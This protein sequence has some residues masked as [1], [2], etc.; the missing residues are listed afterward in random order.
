MPELRPFQ[1]LDLAFHIANPK[2]LNLSDPGTGK[3]PTACVLFYYWWARKGWRTVWAMPKS[4]MQKNHDELLRFTDFAPEDVVVMESDFAPM[5]QGWTGPTFTREKKVKVKLWTDTATGKPVDDSQLDGVMQVEPLNGPD[6]KQQTRLIKVPEIA[7]DL[8]AAA[9]DAK[10]FICTF[11][12]LRNHWERLLKTI[13]SIKGYGIDEL[14]MGY[15]TP[16]SAQTTSFYH[17]ADH[18]EG[19][20]GMTG[21][22]VDGRLDTAFPA[23]HAIEPRYYGGLPGFIHEHAAWINNFDKVES[24]KNEAKLAAILDRHSVRHSFEEVYGKEPVH[25]TPIAE[26]TLEMLPQQLAAYEEFHEQAMLELLDGRILDGSLPG[27]AVIRATQIMA[28]PETF[29][30]AVG[31]ITAKDRRLMEYAV[32]GRPMLVFSAAQPEQERCVKRL[33]ECGLKVGLINANVT[34]AKRSAIDLDFRNGK[35]DAIVGSGPTVAVG[36]NW[37]RADHVVG[38]SWDYKDVNFVQ[39]YRRASRG[40]RQSILR[41]SSLV[42]ANSVDLRKLDI[43]TSKSQT[44]NKVDPS[45]RVLQFA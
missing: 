36:Y 20:L 26:T 30:I 12:F 11:A 22:L 29:G 43:L 13:P 32:E 5:T 41:V 23:I 15:G 37:E 40:T 4:L 14:H 39:A 6:G 18:C 7:K 35:L 44:A 3:T 42:Y 45:R 34:G 31:E 27:V 1:K 9:A 33:E 16:S 28:H 2:S 25:F 21:T 24:W 10:V 38:V 19:L 8:I 17:V